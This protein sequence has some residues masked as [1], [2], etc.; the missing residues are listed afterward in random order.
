MCTVTNKLKL[1]TCNIDAEECYNLPNYW[2]FYKY[3][4]QKED[5]ILGMPMFPLFGDTTSHEYNLQHL[6]ILLNDGNVFDVDLQPKNKDRLRIH[7][8]LHADKSESF[9]YGFEYKNGIWL[10]Q[11]YD[12][13]TWHDRHDE[14]ENGFVK[15]T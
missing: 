9:D 6:P 14:T 5:H 3:S 1:C 10:T 8:T 7:I 2:V 4:K 12:F 13:F 11:E 15:L